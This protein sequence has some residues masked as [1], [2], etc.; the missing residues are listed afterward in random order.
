MEILTMMNQANPVKHALLIAI[1]ALDQIMINALV[2][3]K[4][5]HYNIFFPKNELAILFALKAVIRLILL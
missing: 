4:M 5:E 2:V 3:L 1:H